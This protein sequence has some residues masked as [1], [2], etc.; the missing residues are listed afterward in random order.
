MPANQRSESSNTR[1]ASEG[2]IVRLSVRKPNQFGTESSW[3]LRLNTRAIMHER[4]FKSRCFI[5]CA[6][7]PKKLLNFSA[8]S[9]AEVT[10]SLKS[11][12]RATTF[13]STPKS[14][15]VFR[16]R[17]WASSMMITLPPTKA[18]NVSKP[19]PSSTAQA[20]EAGSKVGSF[21]FT[22]S[23]AFGL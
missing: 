10:T 6:H 21:N 18:G 9:V 16:D 12:R 5:G 1:N 23:C 3:T 4:M 17:S 22:I 2:R 14:T 13:L 11:R 19:A 15:S 20:H 7:P 8:L